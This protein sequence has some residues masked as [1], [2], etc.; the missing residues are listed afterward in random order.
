MWPEGLSKMLPNVYKK[1]P[2]NT[3]L[4]LKND[5]LSKI[6]HICGQFGLKH[7]WF[8]SRMFESRFPLPRKPLKKL[9]NDLYSHLQFYLN[10]FKKFW[11]A[12]ALKLCCIWCLSFQN[13]FFEFPKIVFGSQFRFWSKSWWCGQRYRIAFFNWLIYNAV[14]LAQSRF[15]LMI[16][17]TLG[18]TNF[19]S[20]LQCLLGSCDALLI[21]SNVFQKDKL[22]LSDPNF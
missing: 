8:K 2:K 3:Y 19:W 10:K 21:L 14:S 17:T 6:T 12:I 9:W 22:V 1:L 20:F 18:S 5:T 16:F 7:S 15:F 13:Q 11:D 4:H